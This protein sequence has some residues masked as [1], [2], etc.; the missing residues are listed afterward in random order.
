MSNAQIYTRIGLT[1][2]AFWSAVVCAFWF[3][4]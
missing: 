2:L 1:L 4:T 3:L